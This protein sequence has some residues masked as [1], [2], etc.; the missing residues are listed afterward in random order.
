MTELSGEL[1]ELSLLQARA[2]LDAITFETDRLDARGRL[3]HRQPQP[4]R[5]DERAGG[6]GRLVAADRL[7]RRRPAERSGLRVQRR[8]GNV[9]RQPVAYFA[10]TAAGC[11]WAWSSMPRS[12]GWPNET[13][14]ANR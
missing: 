14:I 1:L 11:A 8:R 7:Q 9:R 3:L 2:R 5:L 4:P 13:C 10:A 12:P 6:A